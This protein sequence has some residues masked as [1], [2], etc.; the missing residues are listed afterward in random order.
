MMLLPTLNLR[1]R[2]GG[3]IALEAE[4]VTPQGRHS[5]APSSK[6][7]FLEAAGKY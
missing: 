1:K 5:K 3:P 6:G 7:T 4:F 2:R